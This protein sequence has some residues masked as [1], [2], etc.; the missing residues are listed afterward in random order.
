L[1]GS[2]VRRKALQLISRVVNYYAYIYKA[3]KDGKFITKD[4]VVKEIRK[5]EM[6]VIASASQIE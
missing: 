5:L 4:Q 1:I 2:I 6:Q 3:N